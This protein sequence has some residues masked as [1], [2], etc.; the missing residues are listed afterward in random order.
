MFK[1]SHMPGHEGDH[2]P[3]HD[4]QV[5]HDQPIFTLMYWDKDKSQRVMID[6]DNWKLSPDRWERRFG[7]GA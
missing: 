4:A 2:G 5:Y 3:V 1:C 7:N 6:L